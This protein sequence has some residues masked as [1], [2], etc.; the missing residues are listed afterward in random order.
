MLNNKFHTVV[1]IVLL[2]ILSLFKTE[3]SSAVSTLY[4]SEWCLI[5]EQLPDVSN[6]MCADTVIVVAVK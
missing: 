3:I 4:Y 5:E 2:K 6:Y 1:Q